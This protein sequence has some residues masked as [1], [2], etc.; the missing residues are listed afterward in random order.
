M[1]TIIITGGS[2]VLGRSIVFDCYEDYKFINLDK[3]SPT[4]LCNG[5]IYIKTDLSDKYQIQDSLLRIESC[6]DL[7]G[8]I[9]C[10]GYGSFN[11]TILDIEYEEWSKIIGINL[12]AA[13]QISRYI[14]PHLV[15]KNLGRIITIG[16]HFASKGGCKLSAY[17]ASK[18]GLLGLIRSLADEW[19]R[20]GI[21]SNMVSPG[22]VDS[23]FGQYQNLNKNIDIQKIPTRRIAQPYE[24]S[25]TIKFLLEENSSYINGANIAVDGGLSAL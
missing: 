11:H 6:E 23:K 24:V 14:I 22:Y 15:K 19:G 1:K 8:F 18:H 10:V 16:S 21:T 2:G 13:Y 9:H 25:T 3:V 17:S 5:E 12:N 7:Y 4:N 20:Y